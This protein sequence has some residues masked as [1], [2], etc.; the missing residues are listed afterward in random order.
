MSGDG[1]SLLAAMCRALQQADVEEIAMGKGKR[2]D[3][4]EPG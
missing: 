2:G 4:A 1:L 3:K